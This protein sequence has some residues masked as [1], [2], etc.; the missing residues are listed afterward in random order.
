MLKYPNIREKYEAWERNGRLMGFDLSSELQ[1]EFEQ[2][3]A[4]K[5]DSWG[6]QPP[7]LAGLRS[8][9][10]WPRDGLSPMRGVGSAGQEGL[11]GGDVSPNEDLG[12][13]VRRKS[14]STASTNLA[15]MGKK[16]SMQLELPPI[17][18]VIENAMKREPVEHPRVRQRTRPDAAWDFL[19]QLDAVGDPM[20]P[21]AERVMY[22]GPIQGYPPGTRDGLVCV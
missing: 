3:E 13:D 6:H 20:G 21:L 18:K 17:T 11:Y 4:A 19:C 10:P 9:E 5:N 16:R 22:A 15:Y 7:M 12:H 2:V 8:G 14:M 1:R